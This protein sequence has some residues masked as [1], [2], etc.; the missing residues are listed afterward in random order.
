LIGSRDHTRGILSRLRG[1]APF[2][3]SSS[4]R[5]SARPVRKI[6]PR[7]GAPVPP[8]VPVCPTCGAA[9]PLPRR[10]V[11]CRYC[12]YKADARLRVCPSCGRTLRPRPWYRNRLLYLTLGLLLLVSGIGISSDWRP[13]LNPQAWLTQARTRV[14]ALLPE[15]TPIALVLIPS[16]TPTST[17]TPTYTPSPTFT[18]TPTPTITPTPTVTPTPT[19]LPPAT[20]Y[21]VQPGDTPATI[22]RQFGIPLEVLLAANDL[23][24]KDVIRVGQELTIP[25][26]T[27]T[28]SPSPTPTRPAPNLR[29]ATP[30]ATVMPT[31][32]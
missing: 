15:M 10:Y 27:P 12:G 29:T 23:T 6:C 11:R 20:K 28:P 7:C 25:L 24:T 17:F 8:G 13:H 5:R 26:P 14:N 19:P 22:A 30:T 1:Q 21:K 3:R 4:T 18:Q 31:S 9:L 32:G 16:P 2:A